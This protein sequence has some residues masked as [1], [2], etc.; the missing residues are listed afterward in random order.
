MDVA[1]TFY[2]VSGKNTCH[3]KGLR[4][5]AEDSVVD[6]KYLVLGMQELKC[7]PPEKSLWDWRRHFE[8]C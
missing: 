1:V 6:M 4:R 2:D 5:R 3:R 8:G 7:V